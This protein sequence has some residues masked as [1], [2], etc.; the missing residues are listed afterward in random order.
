MKEAKYF[1]YVKFV[2]NGSEVLVGQ[3]ASKKLANEMLNKAVNIWGYAKLTH[4]T[5]KGIEVIK[6][7][8]N[9]SKFK[10]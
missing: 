5:N 1:L 9:K 10:K 8:R 2:M 6:I 3:Y 7:K 4:T